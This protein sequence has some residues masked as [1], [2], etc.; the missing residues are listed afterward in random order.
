MKEE[1]KIKIIPSTEEQKNQF[2]KYIARGNEIAIDFANSIDTDQYLDAIQENYE[3]N[4]PE[5]SKTQLNSFPDSIDG[6]EFD[7]HEKILVL[8]DQHEKIKLYDEGKTFFIDN[9]HFLKQ[10]NIHKKD[11]LLDFVTKSQ[12]LFK[13]QEI[14]TPL[15]NIKIMKD[16]N[17]NDLEVKG[18]ERPLKVGDPVSFTN[19]GIIFQ[20][21]VE[22]FG[23]SGET[24]LKITN[25]KEIKSLTVPPGEKIEPM[26]VLDK[27]EKMIYLRFTYEEVTKAIKKTPDF[28]VKFEN[29]KSPIFPLMLGNKTD[30]IPFEKKIDDKM[31]LVEGRLEMRRKPLTGE[32]YVFTDVKFKE[33]NLERPIY[34]L[35][36]DE[37]QRK[38]L[39]KTGELGLISG[40]KTS[41]NKDYN[42]WVSLDSKLNK[43]VTKR[44]ND[45]YIDKIF[46]VTT[47]EEQ[48]NKLKS[49][50]GILMDIN[51]K[52]YFIQASAATTKVDG[53]K[54]YTEEKAKEFKLIPSA[55]KE[56]KKNSKTKGMK[57]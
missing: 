14:L 7:T 48:K 23:K 28:A 49:G 17:V 46:G 3:I 9:D 2:D 44:E 19:D 25:S 24:N 45:I 50:E 35:K 51:T 30:V 37:N 55:E 36:L 27:K 52:K 40:F 8:L 13:S 54:N 5:F 57:V 11:N 34:G 12:A 56:E 10:M 39:E 47:T 31:A 26:F 38:Q 18:L 53:L 42:L 16:Q 20:G 21:K 22:S 4:F 6:Y 33:L 32:P 41:D 15:I 1:F 43:V 29:E